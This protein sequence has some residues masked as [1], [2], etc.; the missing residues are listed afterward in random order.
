MPVEDMGDLG[1]VVDGAAQR[2]GRRAGPRTAASG[3]A[4]TRASSSWC[5]PTAPRS[6]S[7]TPA[8]WP[9]GWPPRLNELA[10]EGIG[11]TERR[12]GQGPPRLAG[13]RAAGRHRGPAEA[14][15][16]CAA[17]S[18]PAASSSASTWARSTSSSRSSRPARC[19]RGLQ[20]IGRAGHQVGEPS[21]GTIFPKHRGDLLE[22][23]VVV[24][25]MRDGLDRDDALPAQPARR[26]RPADRRPR[27][28]HRRVARSTTWPRWSGA[29]PTSPSSPTTLLAQRA[30]PARR[31]A[32]RARSSASCGRASC[33]TAS[34]ARVRGPRRLASG[35][36]S[37][38]AAPSPTAGCS[39]CSCPTARASASST[40][41]WSTR[42]A[43]GETFLLGASHVAHRGHHLRAGHRHARRPA[44]RARCRSG[45]ATGPGRPLELGRALGAFVREIRALPDGDGDR[46]GCATTTA[47]T[48]S[49]P[50]TCVQ[51]L[52]EQAEATGVVPD[53]RTIVVER[54]R[55]EI[56]DWRVCI[57]SAVRHA[58]AR[59][60]GDGD[61]APPRRP[62]RHAGRDDVGRR[63]HRAA[64]ARGGR[65]AC[66]S[67]SCMID[68]DEID[69]LVV[70]DAAADV[71]VRV[72]VP[73]VRGARA[74]AAAPPARSSA[75]RCGSSA[76]GPPTCWRWRPS[77]RRSRSCSRRRASACRTCSTCPRCARCSAEL[78]SRTVRVVS[79]RDAARRRRSRRACCSTGSP[80]TCTRATRRSPSAGPRRWRSTATC[81]AICS[82]P[83]SC[84]SCSTRRARR[85]RARAAVPRRRSPGAQRRRAA[86]RA[87]AG[88]RSRRSTEVRRCARR[89]RRGASAR[90]ARARTRRAIDG[91]RRRC[92]ARFAAAEDAARLPRRARLPRFRSGCRWRSPSRSTHPLET[93][94]ARY[95]RTHGPFLAGRRRP[96]ARRARR[97]RR[98]RA[99]RARGRR[100]GRARR[101]PARRRRARVVRRRRAAPAAAAFAGDAAPR[102][103]AGRARRVR[104]V[105]AGMARR[106][107]AQ[108]RGID[109]L[110]EALGQLQGAAIVASA[111][112]TEVLAGAVAR[113][114][115]ARPRRAVHD[116]RGRVGRRRRDRRQ[117]R[118]RS[119]VLPRPGRGCWRRRPIRSSRRRVAST[120]RSATHLGAAGRQLLVR[121]ARRAAGRHRRRA[122]RA[123]CGIWCGRARSPTTRWRRCASCCSAGKPTASTAPAT[124]RPR[125]GRLTRIGPPAGAGRWSLVAPLALPAPVADRGGARRGACSCSSATASS[126]A[127]R[128]WPKASRAGS[129]RCTPC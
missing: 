117:R 59:A 45:T 2:P 123:R 47:S 110:V 49:P 51:Y 41:R 125:P 40:R 24:R 72:A 109:A 113:V 124:G 14:R 10:E 15:A 22:A 32:T 65:R 70:V 121:A 127:R 66:R 107:P 115:P 19:R 79:R 58:G 62:L 95:A 11:A 17:S 77:T 29:A 26:A 69:E 99:R 36:P 80:P 98:G 73:R 37:P 8:A 101:V 56:G 74:A 129:R 63:R 120:T 54:F 71:A 94:V 108:R 76:S 52:D 55:D 87:A 25:R 104:A 35:W 48:R 67:T 85:P 44:S 126:H 43:P 91:A 57:L 18:P 53:D 97:A 114:P 1:Q 50:A 34:T 7:A 100:A 31:A 9:S 21:T 75:R 3:P 116:R 86:R 83:R 64:P 27:A 102:G 12:A 93:L 13:P 118:P 46:S 92:R 96:P 20:R 111:L 112:E 33:G 78:R 42:A 5:S 28:A 4:S 105:P 16:S 81:C 128:C 61:R 119:P 38:A 39:A 88:R 82:A 103:R 106:P 84:A 23:A 30:R 60:V 90:R 122:A 89:R 68:P 6:S